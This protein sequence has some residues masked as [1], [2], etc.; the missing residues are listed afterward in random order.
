MQKELFDNILL[1]FFKLCI[2]PSSTYIYVNV[3]L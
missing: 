1:L 2:I 3:I